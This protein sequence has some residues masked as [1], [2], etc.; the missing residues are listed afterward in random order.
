MIS[1]RILRVKKSNLIVKRNFIN[2]SKSTT[3]K[4]GI[5]LKQYTKGLVFGVTAGS[6]IYDSFNDFE[7]T[8]GL[9]R[10]LRSLKIA[11]TISIDYS[12][13]LYGLENGTKLY[14]QVRYVSMNIFLYRFVI[15]Y[16]LFI[17]ITILDY[18]GNK[19]T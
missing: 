10:F 18:E 9:S 16:L 15:Y 12:W 7:V 13:N 3:V 14:D 8:G 4:S 2:L 19:F 1:S 17:S 11:A 5:T 6:I